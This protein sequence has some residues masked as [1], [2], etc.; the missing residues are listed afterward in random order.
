MDI[1]SI[2]AIGRVMPVIVIEDSKNAAG[3]GQALLEGGIRTAEITLRTKDALKAIEIMSRDLPELCV[4]AG[5]ILN[6]D[7]ARQARDAG[8]RFAVSPGTTPS[9][10]ESCRK[11][12]LPLLPGAASI[13]EMM[14]LSEQGFGACKFFP[15]SAA[16]GPAFL[17]ACYG[18][19]PHLQFCP[20]GGITPASAPEWLALPNVN[21]L[22][23]S[24][25]ATQKQIAEKDFS[26]I[27]KQARHAAQ[28]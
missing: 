18:P 4:G 9:L 19:L 10:I 24:W 16:G 8:A 1:Y 11:L 13:S 28:L 2:L 5:T 15:A 14:Q 23:G 26:A 6:G 7:H 27:V 3:L 17:K 25:V 12:N 21:C 20:T 22:G